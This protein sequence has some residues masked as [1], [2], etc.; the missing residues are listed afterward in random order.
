MM[1]GVRHTP[2]MVILKMENNH[3]RGDL[4][5]FDTYFGQ[6]MRCFQKGK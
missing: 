1:K 3:L 4:G 6:N 5:N 2:L